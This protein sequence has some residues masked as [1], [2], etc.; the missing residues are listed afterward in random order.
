[1]KKN[2]ILN[3]IKLRQSTIKDYLFCPLLFRF[4]HLEKHE[5]SFRHPAALHGT[6][7]HKIIEA[8]HENGWNLNI[9]Y[10]YHEL[11]EKLEFQSDESHIPMF[12]KDRDKEYDAYLKNGVE[13]LEGY[14]RNKEN[15]EAKV[16]FSETEFRVKICGYWFCGTLDQIRENQDGTTE[17][18]DFKSSKQM[19]TIAFLH[20][21]PP[22]RPNP[23]MPNVRRCTSGIS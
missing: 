16:L 6:V 5:P 2:E 20:N 12:W 8:L 13:I 15:T 23:I 18:L 19:P 1:M 10:M 3:Q 17:L 7:L 9:E 4:R 21:V 14:R 22:I 11:F